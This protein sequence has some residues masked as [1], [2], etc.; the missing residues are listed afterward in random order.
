[1]K[2]RELRHLS[3]K[4]LAYVAIAACSRAGSAVL[5]DRLQQKLAAPEGQALNPEK[6]AD[7]EDVVQWLRMNARATQ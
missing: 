2:G 1:V 7:M 5:A 3:D 4:F 6:R